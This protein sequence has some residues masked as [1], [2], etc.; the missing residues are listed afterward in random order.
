MESEERAA[1]DAL[2]RGELGGLEP[3]VHRY[4]ARALQIATAITGDPAAAEDVVVTAFVQLPE[5]LGSYDPSRPFA[6]WFFRTVSNAALDLLRRHRRELSGEPAA[7]FLLVQPE[8]GSDPEEDSIRMEEAERLH[9]A[10]R[11]LPP[12]HWDVVVRRYYLDMK[13]AATAQALGCPLGTVKW[14]LHDARRRLRQALERL[15]SA[16]EGIA[17]PADVTRLLRAARRSRPAR[18]LEDAPVWRRVRE[19]LPIERRAALDPPTVPVMPIPTGLMRW[20]PDLAAPIPPEATSHVRVMLGEPRPAVP[21]PPSQLE[22]RLGCPLFRLPTGAGVTLL[23]SEYLPPAAWVPT[24]AAVP[25]SA[26]SAPGARLRYALAD[27]SVTLL[28]HR[29]RVAGPPRLPADQTVETV[30]GTDYVVTRDAAG[31]VLGLWCTTA[32]T[33][34]FVRFEPPQERTSAFALAAQ[35]QIGREGT[36]P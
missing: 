6:P 29:W 13:E 15:D 8:P 34:V 14:R 30:E 23:S 20:T 24:G 11:S 10:I 27:V 7:Q 31:R 2:R 36:A 33:Q 19:R 1:L 21:M 28:E 35:L 32:V 18:P 3:L 12:L 9:R 5:R 4:H 17:V 25:Q 26:W 16:A 22:R